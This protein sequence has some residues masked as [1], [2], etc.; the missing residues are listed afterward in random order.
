MKITLKCILEK[1][2]VR[3]RVVWLGLCLVVDVGISNVVQ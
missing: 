3:M 1:L 2:V